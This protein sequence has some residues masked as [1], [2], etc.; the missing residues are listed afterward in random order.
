MNVAL[1]TFSGGGILR[2][3]MMT[4]QL[5]VIFIAMGVEAAAREKEEGEHQALLPALRSDVFTY[6]IP[7]AIACL[8][9]SMIEFCRQEDQ[10][11]HA[12]GQAAKQ[13]AGRFFWCSGVTVHGDPYDTLAMGLIYCV[14]AMFVA[15]VLFHVIQ[16]FTAVL[17]A[18]ARQRLIITAAAGGL[19]IIIA[20]LLAEYKIWIPFS[21]DIGILGVFYMA[22]GYLLYSIWQERTAAAA[23]KAG[24]VRMT[25]AVVLTALAAAL[26]AA[27]CVIAF[28][29]GVY[30]EPAARHYSP[31]AVLTSLC[32]CVLF[33][34]AA[35]AV[36]SILARVFRFEPELSL[37]Q[38]IGRHPALFMCVHFCDF[39][40]VVFYTYRRLGTS[41]SL[42]FIARLCFIIATMFFITAFAKLWAELGEKQPEQAAELGKKS[43]VYL[44]EDIPF[45]D[46]VRKIRNRLTPLHTAAFYIVFSYLY[47]NSFLRT[48]MIPSLIGHFGYS[49]DFYFSQ[50]CAA[51]LMSLIA[52]VSIF[53]L[54]NRKE[55]AL[56][57]SVFLT[58]YLHWFV[59]GFFDVIELFI[60]IVAAAGQD[61]KKILKIAFGIG[62]TVMIA[63]FWL[64]QNGYIYD[65]VRD[66]WG[67]IYDYH[68]FGIINTTDW[69]A[70]MMFL[71]LNWYLIRNGSMT[72]LEY[73]VMIFILRFNMVLVH[74]KTDIVC[75]ALFIVLAGGLQGW[76]YLRS[77]TG[78]KRWKLVDQ[79]ERLIKRAG[80]YAISVF[81]LLC[82]ASMF[83]A[84]CL[85]GITGNML[86]DRVSRLFLST[87]SRAK[88]SWEALSS[89]SVK[90]FGSSIYEHG[91]GAQF[92]LP[93]GAEYFF[94]DSLY[95]RWFVVY[96]LAAFVLLNILVNR[97]YV[98]AL[99][100]KYYAII[101]AISVMIAGAVME[102]FAGVIAYNV[103][104]MF[105][106]AGYHDQIV[107]TDTRNM[108]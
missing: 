72:L 70:H 95:I 106:F 90:L 13:F 54:K 44:E 42:Q 78:I 31:A 4:V 98:Q 18:S 45:L 75:M 16:V 94:L 71:M 67:S 77:R 62:I 107:M 46:L 30:L 19:S 47:L 2:S 68:S 92:Q 25:V 8:L 80:K 3:V 15:S 53:K 14:A 37:L 55:L 24:S 50:R 97:T 74:G 65:I 58:G 43:T 61:F 40:F 102:H 56:A 52:A 96:G 1:H 101:V 104:L 108:L 91:Y 93:A 6:F 23:V 73:A 79:L 89:N 27:V 34:M 59:R 83:I 103:L 29:K 39:V 33:F 76:R 11:L 12:I 105:V 51:Y 5:P 49:D 7:L 21:A 87:D 38:Y 36:Y 48:T 84:A 20:V 28:R 10:G 9:S 69:A 57:L 86:A 99:K 82:T 35:G 85:Y 63:A 60:P 26:S 22:L 81:H 88:Q 17:Q 41:H 32:G 100:Q 66:V 64:S